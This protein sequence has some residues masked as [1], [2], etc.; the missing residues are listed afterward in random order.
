MS[1]STAGIV[2]RQR[3]GLALKD[4]RTAA[5]NADGGPIMQT[6]AAKAIK[7][8]TIDRVS[9]MERGAAWPEPAEL[10]AL[11]KLYGADVETRVRLETMLRE[12]TA[13]SSAW[14]QAYEDDFHESLLEFVAYEDAAAEIITCAGAVVPGL[15]QTTEYA[16]AITAHLAKQTVTTHLV[17][18]SVDL[19]AMRRRVLDRD[20]RPAVEAIIG[21]AALRQQ[22]G[23]RTVMVAQ[24]DALLDDAAQR[25]VTFRVSPFEAGAT[26]TY[27]L[28]LFTFGGGDELPIAAFDAVT[29]MSF[30][31]TAKEVRGVKGF[32]DA[33]R[34]LALSGEDSLEMIRTIRKEMSRD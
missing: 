8:R 12:G 13:I 16:H 14:W 25:G 10:A 7:R 17:E 23:G 32:I 1:V 26:T 27:L 9:R 4:V 3:F 20:N 18:R 19:R 30:R 22:V 34:E 28:H 15:L 5:R 33:C 31:K 6:D 11:L 24:L 2:A 21:E 29:G